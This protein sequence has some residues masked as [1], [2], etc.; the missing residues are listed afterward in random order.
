MKKLFCVLA[1]CVL[2]GINLL[3]CASSKGTV[4]AQSAVSTQTEA[5][6]TIE[7]TGFKK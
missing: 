2:I 1:S 7:D 6:E 3:S 4:K 5:T